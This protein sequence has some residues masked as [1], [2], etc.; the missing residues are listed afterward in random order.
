[1]SSHDK[2]YLSKYSVMDTAIKINETHESSKSARKVLQANVYT[3]KRIM[4]WFRHRATEA[5]GRRHLTLHGA[6]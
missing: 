2:P 5:Q 4:L 1:M 6:I 3:R